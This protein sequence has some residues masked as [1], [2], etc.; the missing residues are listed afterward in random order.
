MRERFEVVGQVGFTAAAVF[1]ATLGVVVLDVRAAKAGDGP[2]RVTLLRTPH[3]GIQPQATVDA[4][5]AIHLVAFKGDPAAGDI[6]YT[7]LDPGADTFTPPVPVNSQPGSAVAK[8]TIRGAQ[9]AI[10]RGGRV[11]VA[12]NGSGQARPEN[13]NGGTPML[14]SRSDPARSAFEPQRNLMQRT[15]TLD[16]GGTIA[17]DGK[18]RVLVAWHARPLDALQGESN[19][20]MFVARSDDDG[21]TFSPESP[22]VE[23]ETGACACCGTRALLT[24][25][26]TAYMLF[27]AATRG[28]HRDMTLLASRDRGG[29]FEAKRVDEW[30]LN[31][32]PMSSSS[33]AEGPS[34]VLAAWETQGQ[35]YVA[36]IDPETGAFSIPVHPRGS[37]GNRKHPSVAV[38][39]RGDY[40]VAWAEDTSFLR[41]GSLAWRVHDPSGKPIGE[42]GRLDGGIPLFSLPTAVARPDGSFTIIH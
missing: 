13:P 11:H 16:G 39:R 6:F 15:S 5:G 37:G 3:G 7:R 35:V 19:R 26:G 29:H 4:S 22:A 30:A 21:V 23:T 36:R 17:A 41:G 18:G 12:W 1:V 27:R 2:A 34:G 28:T 14:Y 20:R 32:C 24:P 9:I 42:T 31:M 33:L 8:G 38:N 10:G 25:S 40:V